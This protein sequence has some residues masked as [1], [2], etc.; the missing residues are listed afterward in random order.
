MHHR[1]RFFLAL[2]AIAVLSAVC[3]FVFRPPV[4]EYAKVERISLMIDGLAVPLS[5]QDTGAK[6][7]GEFLHERQV[8]LGPEDRVFPMPEAALTSGMHITIDRARTFTLEADGETKTFASRALS[9]GEALSDT[10]LVLDEDDIVSPDVEEP[11]ADRTAV[12]V[13]RVAVTEESVEKPIPFETETKEDDELSWRK[14]IVTTKG[15]KGCGAPDLPSGS[16]RR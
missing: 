12:Q 4:P 10:G 9:I 8:A 7:V 16:P 11:L 13:I 5:A 6:T 14:K 1:S 3:F 2:L 15:G